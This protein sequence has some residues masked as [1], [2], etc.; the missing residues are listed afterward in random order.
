MGDTDQD[1][2]ER[3]KAR[4]NVPAP[5]PGDRMLAKQGTSLPTTAAVIIN[6]GIVVGMLYFVTGLCS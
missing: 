3:P 4:S 1:D 6:V 5:M 2:G